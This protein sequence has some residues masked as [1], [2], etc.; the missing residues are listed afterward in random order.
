MNLLK[1]FSEI[2]QKN[3][4]K[5]AVIDDHK[6]ITFREL[7]IFSDIIAN[8]LRTKLKIKTYDTIS[9]AAEKKVDT[10]CLVL[11]CIK[12]GVCYNFFDPYQ[13]KART[14]KI[15]NTINPRY[16]FLT[17]KSKKILVPDNYEIKIIKNF[18]SNQKYIKEKINYQNFSILAPLYVMFT[19]GSTGFPKGSTISHRN[20]LNFVEWS[21]KEYKISSSDT[22]SNLNPLYFDNS[23]F[24][25]YAS[26]FNGATLLLVSK[27][28]VLNPKEL[29]KKLIENKTTIWFSVPT[30]IIYFLKFTKF[31]ENN[32]KHL[33]CII[34][35]G[36]PFPKKELF[37][38]YKDLKKKIKL[39]NVYG[40]SECTCICS[41]YEISSR[42][43]T[44]LEMKRFAP[45]GKKLIENFKYIIWDEHKKNQI[46]RPNK[47]G[48]L[49][50]GGENVGLGYFNDP[51]MTKEKFIQNPLNSKYLDIYYSSGDLVYFDKKYIYF[52]G[53]KDDQ[54]KYLGYRI[55]LA[56]IENAINSLT[57]VKQSIV[58]FGKKN[59]KQEITAWVLLEKNKKLN[60]QSKLKKKLPYYML[61][62]IHYVTNFKINQ[63]GKINRKYI[64]E[65]YYD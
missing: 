17:K 53:R 2:V 1:K 52:A 19:S 49:L 55:E 34:F 32:F 36:E 13:P 56:E 47:I 15:L 54:I 22:I 50:I 5:I 45:L 9:I 58:L 8:Q 25:F 24:D 41:N 7:D 65:K 10:V 57:Y 38:L 61:P 26:L 31:S 60:I 51:K 27:D 35:G 3:K 20:I 14:K 33:R 46:N 23:I 42:D 12:L 6:K 62:K 63:N 59:N 39:F 28:T 64:S 4:N 21:R 29:S 18:Y 48:E 43:F 44:P 16:I 11:S 40:P 37:N 30:L